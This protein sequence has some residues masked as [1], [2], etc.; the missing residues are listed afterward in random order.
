[1][2]CVCLFKCN[3]FILFLFIIRKVIG[4]IEIFLLFFLL[5]GWWFECFILLNLFLLVVNLK[6]IFEIVRI[7]FLFVVLIGLLIIVFILVIC[8]KCCIVVVIKFWIGWFILYFF[9][10]WIDFFVILD[11]CFFIN[12]SNLMLVFIVWNIWKDVV[13]LYFDV[14]FFFWKIGVILNFGM[15][16]ICIYCLIILVVI[17]FVFYVYLVIILVLVVLF[18]LICVCYF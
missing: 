10:V 18:V 5:N 16:I 13:N 2:M 9:Y 11:F 3:I 4:L 12:M 1:M 8:F 17:F 7:M 15:S 14:N 6:F